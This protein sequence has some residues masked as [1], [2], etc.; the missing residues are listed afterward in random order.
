MF[1]IIN[2]WLD[3][4]RKVNFLATIVS[5]YGLLSLGARAFVGTLI[6]KSILFF[7][8]LKEKEKK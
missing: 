6:T 3:F 8:F 1:K 2:T 5:A 7:V 4:E